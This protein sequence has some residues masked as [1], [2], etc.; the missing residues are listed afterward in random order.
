VERD[1]MG[2]LKLVNRESEMTALKRVVYLI[3]LCAA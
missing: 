2:H 3:N 1:E